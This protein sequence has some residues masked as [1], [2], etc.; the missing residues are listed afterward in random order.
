M[1]N[2]DKFILILDKLSNIGERTA[3]MEV[4]NE[5]MIKDIAIIKEEDSRQNNLLDEHIKGTV[6]NTDR[7]NLEIKAREDLEKTQKTMESRLGEVERIPQFMKSLYKI[8]MYL[9]GFVGLVY[10]TGRILKKW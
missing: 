5:T 6:T 1:D 7:L 4:Q 9:G 2:D 8:A 3:R 10:E